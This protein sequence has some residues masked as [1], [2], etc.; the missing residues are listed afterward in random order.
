MKVYRGIY[1]NI[2]LFPSVHALLYENT[3]FSVLYPIPD[4]YYVI[5]IITYVLIVAAFISRSFEKTALRFF[6]QARGQ[7]D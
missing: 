7:Q 1:A 5:L 3:K 2:F 4:Y 6:P